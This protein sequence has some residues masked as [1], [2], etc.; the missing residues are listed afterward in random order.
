MVFNSSL[1]NISVIS[2][3][4][5]LLV[6]KTGVSWENHQPV[7]CHWQTL[8]LLRGKPDMIHK[9]LETNLCRFFFIVWL[10][11]PVLSL[12]T[13][14]S[15]GDLIYRFDPSQM[16]SCSKT[17]PAFPMSYV[18]VCFCVQRFEVRGYGSFCWYWSN[19]LYLLDI[20]LRG[21]NT[22]HLNMHGK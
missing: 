5:V 2:L 7:A 19:C 6:E 16:C 4:S 10:H 9:W 20:R 17:G 18:V 11:A 22:L 14:L 1:N 12:E 15:K 3:R 13:Q 8:A 21:I